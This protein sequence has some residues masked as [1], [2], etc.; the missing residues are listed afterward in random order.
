M[1][2]QIIIKIIKYLSI[3]ILKFINFSKFKSLKENTILKEST[4][5]LDLLFNHLYNY[6]DEILKNKGLSGV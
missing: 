3:S 6:Y 1:I 2:I 5:T 4:L